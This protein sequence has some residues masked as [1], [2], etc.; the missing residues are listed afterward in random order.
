MIF[1]GINKLNSKTIRSPSASL[2]SSLPRTP[3]RWVPGPMGAWVRGRPARPHAGSASESARPAHS[4][5]TILPPPSVLLGSLPAPVARC[6]RRPG[7]GL[8]LRALPRAG[9]GAASR[10]R[11]RPEPGLSEEL[12]SPFSLK[13]PGGE[14]TGLCKGCWGCTRALGGAAQGCGGQ[15]SPAPGCLPDAPQCFKI[16]KKKKLVCSEQIKGGCCRCAWSFT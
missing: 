8:L 3:R 9:G 13:G 14:G 1:S 11:P 15:I 12:L 4:H 10:P 2:W 5:R 16:K 7:R 6:P